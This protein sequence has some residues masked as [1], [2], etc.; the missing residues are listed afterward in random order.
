MSKTLPTLPPPDTKRSE[1]LTAL[2]QHNVVLPPLWEVDDPDARF[3]SGAY[4]EVTESNCVRWLSPGFLH[5]LDQATEFMVTVK[6]L[7]ALRFDLKR[8]VHL[9]QWYRAIGKTPA[10]GDEWIGERLKKGDSL[11]AI[12]V[13]YLRP[14]RESWGGGGEG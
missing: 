2:G 14:G 10:P 11:P 5:W 9:E 4:W 8:L 7:H 13:V 3:P 1:I 6:E 12:A